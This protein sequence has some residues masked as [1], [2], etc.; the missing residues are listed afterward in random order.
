MP[1]QPAFLLTIHAPH[2]DQNPFFP[3]SIKVCVPRSALFPSLLFQQSAI[4]AGFLTSDA[5]PLSSQNPSSSPNVA[6]KPAILSKLPVPDPTRMYV[7][8]CNSPRLRPRL[9]TPNPPT[10]Q[11]QRYR[12]P[13]FQSFQGALNATNLFWFV[14]L[15][16][17]TCFFRSSHPTTPPSCPS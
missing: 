13:V 11:T 15:P 12:H 2:W 10:Y 16:S 8:T 9:R 6:C 5:C 14:L 3:S 1:F 7:C 17:S 4:P